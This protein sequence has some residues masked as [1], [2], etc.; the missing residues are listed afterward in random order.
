MRKLDILI[1]AATAALATVVASPA[2]AVQSDA[3][4][5]QVTLGAAGPAAMDQ[6]SARSSANPFVAQVEAV[7]A[8]RAYSFQAT[9]EVIRFADAASAEQIAPGLSSRGDGAELAFLGLGLD[10]GKFQRVGKGTS[11]TTDDQGNRQ[12]YAWNGSDNIQVALQAG[13]NNSSSQ[14]SVGSRNISFVLQDGSTN[15]AMTQQFAEATLA[16]ILQHGSNNTAS[17]Y[18]HTDASVAFVSQS[19]TGNVISLRQ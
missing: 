9:T 15:R 3:F 13:T 19:G 4:V 16:L 10:L 2:M 12:Y 17:I 14:E 18:Q 1:S 6:V 5:D 7:D 11:D 8:G